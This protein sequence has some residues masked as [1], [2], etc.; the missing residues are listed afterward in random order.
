MLDMRRR[1]FIT[2]V[3]G[4][5]T[6]PL[7]AHG[8]QPAMPLVGYLSIGSPE[9]VGHLVAQFRQG[10]S[11]A[12]Y[13][14]GRTVAIEYRWSGTQFGP[15]PALAA[16]LVRRQAEV[17]YA[18]SLPAVHAAKMATPTIPIVFSMGEDPVKEGIVASLSRPDGNVTG[19]TDFSNQ[20]AGKRLGLL[21][22]IAPATA[23]L[24]L[25]V[26]P[27]NPN[28]APDT[29]D[30]QVAAAALGRELKVFTASAERDLATVF[31]AM[32][33]MR[34]GALFVN[35]DPYFFARREQLVALASRYRLPVLFDRRDYPLAGG[36]MSYG[37]DLREV[38][39]QSGIYVGR[40]LK[41]SK[42]SELPVQQATKFEF[43]INLRTA[44]ALG[45]TIPEG[46]VIAADEVIE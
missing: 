35:V 12:G 46:L 7:A 42:P 5:A 33:D 29:R 16:D 20:L 37:T 10:L 3:G 13:M 45:L 22:D 39:R 18:R 2:L 38:Y 27:T 14:E 19:F 34:L 1:E 15:M 36:L 40:I 21:R 41:G 25:L 28:A 30:A 9:S 4:A 44:K 6:W 23:A 26:N 24:G 32:V 17:L 11:D 43:I 8:Q 31:D